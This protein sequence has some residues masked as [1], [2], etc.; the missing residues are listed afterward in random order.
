M[1]IDQIQ[2]LEE[3]YELANELLLQDLENITSSEVESLT[4]EIVKSNPTPLKVELWAQILLWVEP[5]ERPE[6]GE[7]SQK[8]DLAKEE[9]TTVDWNSESP[10][11]DAS[12]FSEAEYDA[13]A[14]LENAYHLK[15]LKDKY[16]PNETNAQLKKNTIQYLYDYICKHNS[17]AWSPSSMKTLGFWDSGNLEKAIQK[18][19]GIPSYA[20]DGLLWETSKKYIQVYLWIL[21]ASVLI[22]KSESKKD[23]SEEIIENKEDKDISLEWGRGQEDLPSKKKSLQEKMKEWAQWAQWSVT[24]EKKESEVWWDVI[25]KDT[26][27]KK[28]TLQEKMKEWAQWAQWSVTWEKKESEVW[29][30]VIDKD[31]SSKKKTLQEKMKEWAQWAQWSVTWEKKESEVWWDTTGQ[32]SRSADIENQRSHKSLAD[33]AKEATQATIKDS[34]VLEAEEDFEASENVLAT[35]ISNPWFT[36]YVNYLD[37]ISMK[38]EW[39]S[40]KDYCSTY[41]T[42]S[43]C[44]ALKSQWKVL[45]NNFSKLR[46][47]WSAWELKDTLTEPYFSQNSLYKVPT[48]SLYDLL[49]N[50]AKWAVMTVQYEDSGYKEHGITHSIVSLWGGKFQDWAGWSVREFSLSPDAL[51]KDA[52]GTYFKLNGKKYHFVEDSKLISPEPEQFSSGS[53]VHFSS[54]KTTTIATWAQELADKFQIPKETVVMKILEKKPDADFNTYYSVGQL[55]CDLPVVLSSPNLISTARVDLTKLTSE[56]TSY[57]KKVEESKILAEELDIDAEGSNFTTLMLVLKKEWFTSTDNVDKSQKM[58][59]AYTFDEWSWE[60]YKS[61]LVDRLVP[62]LEDQKSYLPDGLVDKTKKLLL[63]NQEKISDF[64]EFMHKEFWRDGIIVLNYLNKEFSSFPAVKKIRILT[65]LAVALKSSTNFV[66]WALWWS[67]LVILFNQLKN[68][69]YEKWIVPQTFWPYQISIDNLKSWFISNSLFKDKFFELL[70]ESEYAEHKDAIEKIL[71]GEQ[72]DTQELEQVCFDPKISLYISHWLNGDNMSKIMT[73]LREIDVNEVDKNDL[74]LTTFYTYNR[75]LPKTSIAIWQQN[76]YFLVQ[77]FGDISLPS[78][79]SLDWALWTQTDTLITSLNTKLWTTISR[80]GSLL[81]YEGKEYNFRTFSDSK[82]FFLTL[83]TKYPEY[84]SNFVYQAA[85]DY[86]ALGVLYNQKKIKVPYAYL[87]LEN[88]V[89]DNELAV[90]KA[91]VSLVNTV[92]ISEQTH[93]ISGLSLNWKEKINLESS[94]DLWYARVLEK[95]EGKIDSPFLYKSASSPDY[96]LQ[97]S[98]IGADIPLFKKSELGEDLFNKL[99]TDNNKAKILEWFRKEK[100]PS[101]TKIDLFRD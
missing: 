44:D 38:E 17:G 98:V 28:K 35:K 94:L 101:W 21:P 70:A 42:Q 75:G 55:E 34:E 27:S 56:Q 76:L 29:W 15:A 48:S 11:L 36:K 78:N 25:D 14:Y 95:L 5:L 67:A 58:D 7:I 62:K 86:S 59:I 63:N 100:H 93:I 43:F 51:W 71:S 49:A 19:V 20:Q 90:K 45:P 57:A 47:P 30:D 32:R 89:T 96:L 73:K 31:T 99:N 60:I 37:K 54:E 46:N 88:S 12:E 87:Y 53:S 81:L 91:F 72:K 1:S 82:K 16:F 50:A 77:S 2:D 66:A 22:E 9:S 83:K 40:D 79:Y 74:E 68:E 26:S 52:I 41:T 18:E 64:A 80:S 33:K 4:D 39:K 24:W 13:K 61:L 65:T 3:K 8:N 92:D 84:F 6:Q 10:S 97:Y 85:L 69:A 23:S